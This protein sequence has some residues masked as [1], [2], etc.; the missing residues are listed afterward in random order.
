[1][2]FVEDDA[3]V[4]QMYRLKLEL[5]GY[6]VDVASDGEMALQMVR[7]SVP[8]L[9]FMDIRLPKLGGLEVLEALR[10][11]PQT[12]QGPGGH[13][14]EQLGTRAGRARR[15][16][17]R[18]RPPDQEQDHSGAARRRRRGMAPELSPRPT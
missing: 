4:A 9:I 13:P 3:A 7:R 2:L 16:V 15:Q 11:D 14:L 5:D 17:G 10:R 18:S 1:V 6:R 12:K 8:D